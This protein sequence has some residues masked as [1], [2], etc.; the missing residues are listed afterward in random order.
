MGK[1]IGREGMRGD[2]NLPKGRFTHY[3]RNPEKYPD[4]RTYLFGGGGNTDVYP[5]G[6]HRRAATG[7]AFSISFI[8]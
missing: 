8:H 5:G 3:V 6:K 2:P 1:R 7:L 4:C